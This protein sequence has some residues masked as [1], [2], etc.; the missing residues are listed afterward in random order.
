[1]L[2]LLFG[3]I[4]DGGVLLLGLAF[5]DGQHI[6]LFDDEVLLAVQLDLLAR[7]LAE[8]DTVAAL[9]ARGIRLRSSF[10]RPLPAAMTVA[11]CGFSLAVSG[12]IIPPTCCSRSSM[13]CT[14][15]RSSSGL[16]VMDVDSRGV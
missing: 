16:T 11:C 12:M 15:M 6:I 3:L 10:I 14:M 9:A 1:L 7:I 4:F 13:R 8:Q 5:D 2:L